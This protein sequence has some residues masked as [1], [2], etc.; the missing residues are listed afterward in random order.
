LGVNRLLENKRM[1]VV[2][3]QNYTES[4]KQY[5]VSRVELD[6]ALGGYLFRLLSQ[7]ECI[8]GVLE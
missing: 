2:A 1:E 8:Q 5:L 4:V 3:N 6:R 7:R